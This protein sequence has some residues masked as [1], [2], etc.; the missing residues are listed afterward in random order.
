MSDPSD[1]DLLMSRID[2]IR[3]TGQRHWA[4][5]YM[6][7][8]WATE[9]ELD[10]EFVTAVNWREAI[11]KHSK[12]GFVNGDDLENM[13]QDIEAV[14]Q[15]FFDMDSMIDVKELPNGQ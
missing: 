15:W 4:V 8:N 2:E 3:T 9:Y 13:P 5:A 11:A 6:Y 7:I 14:K 10:I 12:V 1:L